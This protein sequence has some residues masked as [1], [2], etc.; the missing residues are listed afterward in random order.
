MNAD[1]PAPTPP[2]EPTPKPEPTIT[3]ATCPDCGGPLCVEVD[4][5]TREE[6]DAYKEQLRREADMR[7]MFAREKEY[8]REKEL[9]ELRERQSVELREADDRI[10]LVRAERDAF[11]AALQHVLIA[12]DA[13]DGEH[14]KDGLTDAALVNV[15]RKIVRKTLGVVEE[16]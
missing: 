3:P 1:A 6:F 8:Q 9:A 13:A 5:V 2:E 15:A 7:N 4:L 14:D 11:H 12:L 16:K 10:R